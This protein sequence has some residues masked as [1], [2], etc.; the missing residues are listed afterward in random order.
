MTAF[1]SLVV[2]L[3]AVSTEP[4]CAVPVIEAGVVNT[5]VLFVTTLVAVLLDVMLGPPSASV[6]VSTTRSRFP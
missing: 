5:R 3:T 2:P 4:S 1:R 6:A